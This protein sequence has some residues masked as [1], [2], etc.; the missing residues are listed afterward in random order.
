MEIIAVSVAVITGIFSVIGQFIIS[1][2]TANKT[3]A[4]TDVR[5]NTI[6]AK[7]DKHNCFMERVAVLEANQKNFASVIQE[8]RNNG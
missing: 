7:L 4:V 5:L 3:Q 1:N 6:E 2:R 8:L